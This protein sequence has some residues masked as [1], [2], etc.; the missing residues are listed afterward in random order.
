MLLSDATTIKLLLYFMNFGKLFYDSKPWMPSRHSLHGKQKEVPK[1]ENK[2][3]PLF[4]TTET[5]MGVCQ[6][7]S[8]LFIEGLISVQRFFEYSQ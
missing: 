2:R 7:M 8:M 4:A 3:F 1:A 6:R 5:Q